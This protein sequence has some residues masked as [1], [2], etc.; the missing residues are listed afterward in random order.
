MC[1]GSNSSALNVAKD[2]VTSRTGLIKDSVTSRTGLIK[3]VQSVKLKKLKAMIDS[4]VATD[5][6]KKE[7]AELTKK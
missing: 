2:S 5:E 7:Y 6:Q 1:I 3:T 4:D